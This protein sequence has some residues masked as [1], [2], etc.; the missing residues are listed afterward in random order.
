[1]SWTGPTGT[2]GLTGPTGPIAQS[3]MI[4][5]NPFIS[6]TFD[7]T[8]TRIQWGSINANSTDGGING[9]VYNPDGS[10]TNQSSGIII[11]EVQYNL[12]WNQLVSG[13]TYV[14]S[15]NIN[16]GYTQYNTPY[17]T[18]TVLIVLNPYSSMSVYCQNS[19]SG[20][21]LQTPSNI[22]I[23]TL[24]V[25]PIGPTGLT[26]YTGM[27]VK[28]SI[29]QNTITI[30]GTISN[31]VFTG[32]RI[33][34]LGY[35]LI[36]DKLRVIYKMGWQGGSSAGNGD[37]LISLPNGISFN[38]GGQYN[39]VYTGPIFPGDLSTVANALIP[40]L[41]GIIERINWAT[42]C[43]VVPYNATQFRLVLPYNGSL[44]T[45]NS[46][47]YGVNNATFNLEVEIWS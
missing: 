7:L 29:I 13:I 25:G 35:R 23:S 11:L 46:T 18:N 24:S 1:M 38:I 22:T 16:Y 40:A 37:Y 3:T 28:N 8:S 20:L 39:A 41:G 12:K 21:V 31:P 47:T 4:S 19:S 44:Q 33:Q 14:T 17:V 43:Y 45:W 36:G 34:Q 27:G 9:L 5:M 15:N 30:R 6:Q 10:F 2:R 32:I 26:G 42:S